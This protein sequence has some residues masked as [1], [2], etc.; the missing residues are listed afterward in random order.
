MLGEGTE[1]GAWHQLKG[2]LVSQEET[3]HSSNVSYQLTYFLYVSDFEGGLGE[4][5]RML[6]CLLL[7]S[8]LAFSP[9]ACIF[10]WSVK[11]GG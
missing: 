8:E 3:S 4:G 6:A 11:D 9:M 7:P 1:C 5:S 10:G 2:N